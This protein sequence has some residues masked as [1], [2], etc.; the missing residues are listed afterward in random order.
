MMQTGGPGRP[1][2]MGQSQGISYSTLYITFALLIGLVGLSTIF[3]SNSA[4]FLLLF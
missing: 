2:M 4:L 1:V 3:F